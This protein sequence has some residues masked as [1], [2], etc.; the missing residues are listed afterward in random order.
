MFN[1][2]TGVY[3]TPLQQLQFG[4][5]KFLELVR[6]NV[7]DLELLERADKMDSIKFQEEYVLKFVD[8]VIC[9]EAFANLSFND[10]VRHN[11]S[12]KHARFSCLIITIIIHRQKGSSLGYFGA[13]IRIIQI[14]TNARN[15]FNRNVKEK[16]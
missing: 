6:P 9:C 1:I 15:S 11:A 16:L 7:D 10:K 8:V 5:S 12:S 3:M 2:P 13:T 4:F 14:S